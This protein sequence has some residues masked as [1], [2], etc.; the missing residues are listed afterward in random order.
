MPL[1]FDD[2]LKFNPYH[3]SRGRFS[4]ADSAA[5]FTYAPGKSTEHDAAIQ[6]AKD[7]DGAG[8]GKGFKGTLYHGSPHKD[9]EE[10]DISRAGENTSSGEKLI[11]FTDSKQMAED[12]SYERLEG[13]SKYFQRRGE[14]GRVYEVNV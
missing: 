9:I 7:A 5:S 4:S 11:Y 3:D 1:C 2:I 10:F 14:K 12:F 8:T 6:R 13:S